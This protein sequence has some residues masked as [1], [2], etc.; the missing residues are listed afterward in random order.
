MER[1]GFNQG[2]EKSTDW[3]GGIFE[4]YSPPCFLYFIQLA[5]QINPFISQI[6]CTKE[7][8]LIQE[9]QGLYIRK[10]YSIGLLESKALAL[11]L[12]ECGLG[13]SAKHHELSVLRCNPFLY[14]ILPCN[15]P[16]PSQQLWTPIIRQYNPF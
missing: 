5:R 7:V 6:R 12:I 16:L 11:A 8:V 1:C 10:D 14:T 15:Y 13:F 3:C 4:F 2:F 9:L